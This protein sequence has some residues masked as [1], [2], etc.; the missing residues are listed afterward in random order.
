MV[1]DALA[2]AMELTMKAGCTPSQ[3]LLKFTGIIGRGG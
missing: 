1:V 2:K 3:Q